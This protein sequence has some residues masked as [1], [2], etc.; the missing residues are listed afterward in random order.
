MIE[1]HE[2]RYVGRC[3]ER[4][5][6]AHTAYGWCKNSWSIAITKQALYTWFGVSSRPDEE[7]TLYNMLGIAQTATDQDVKT[8][9]KRMA[10]QWHPDVCREPDARKQFDAIKHAYNVLSTKRAKYDAGLALQAS[11]YVAPVSM[12]NLLSDA[13]GYRSPLRCGWILGEGAYDNRRKFVIERVLGWEDIV[14]ADGK[15][16]VASW[17]YGQDAPLEEWV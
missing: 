10:K 5:G 17:I 7:T 3:K 8:A 15:T 9:Y 16:L 14:R 6:G 12:E 13:Y 4:Q 1:L 2:V 11:L